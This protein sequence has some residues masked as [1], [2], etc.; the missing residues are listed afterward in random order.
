MFYSDYLL[1]PSLFSAAVFILLFSFICCCEV[2]PPHCKNAQGQAG[3]DGLLR[4]KILELCRHQLLD[5][6]SYVCIMDDHHPLDDSMTLAWGH[7]DQK[8]II[9]GESSIV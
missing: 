5:S 2:L 7:G 1:S 3:V 8:Y 4:K 6:F 9:F